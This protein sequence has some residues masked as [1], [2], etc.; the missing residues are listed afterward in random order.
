M[1]IFCVEDGYFSF[2]LRR[3]KLVLRKV[4]GGSC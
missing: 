2:D 1:R 3:W 4:G